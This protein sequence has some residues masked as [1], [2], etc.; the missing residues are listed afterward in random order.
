MK[1]PNP[2]LFVTSLTA[3]EALSGSLYYIALGK[4]QT[5]GVIGIVTVSISISMLFSSVLS[6]NFGSGFAHYISYYKGADKNLSSIIRKF[7]LVSSLVSLLSFITVYLLSPAL[8]ILFYHSIKLDFYLHE[9]SFFVFLIV[10]N[11]LM[12]S[13]L[14][15]SQ[16]FIHMSISGSVFFAIS[17][18]FSYTELILTGSVNG[19]LIGLSYGGI[20]GISISSALLLLGQKE[21]ELTKNKPS[22]TSKEFL[23]YV[24]P[25]YI[26]TISGSLFGYVDKLFIAYFTDVNVTGVY[27][28]I[29]TIFGVLSILSGPIINILFPKFSEFHGKGDKVTIARIFDISMKFLF[30]IYVPAALGGALIA[31]RFMNIIAG[32]D[33]SRYSYILSFLLLSSLIYGYRP[34][35]TNTLQ[36]IRETQAIMKSGIFG[37]ALNIFLSIVLIPLLGI[38]GG[39]I[40]LSASLFLITFLRQE[41]LKRNI[42]I[43]IISTELLK[44]L[45]ISLM[46]C[47]VVIA[48]NLILPTT[49][50]SLIFIIV[51][52]IFVYLIMLKIIAPLKLEKENIRQLIGNYGGLFFQILNFFV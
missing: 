26:G 12:Q 10:L 28:Y 14:Q 35:V 31:N 41:S 8:A 38:L 39:A 47:I 13:M 7:L 5:L 17:Y 2:I 9:I 19:A 44:I 15:G 52:A 36:A 6:L 22:L 29:V 25:T 21:K 27:L 33:I 45:G 23:S 49:V 48:M 4:T 34:I 42:P 51:V 43:K 3:L 20:I 46:M 1:N 30:L 24:I 50:L 16:R 18:I 32:P 40:S 11:T 37:L